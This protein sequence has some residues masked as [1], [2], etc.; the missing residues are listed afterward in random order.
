[1]PNHCV[2]TFAFRVVC[3][4]LLSTPCLPLSPQ[5]TASEPLA[6]KP[7]LSVQRLL[8]E[9]ARFADTDQFLDSLK[10][11]DQALDAAQK[12]S[13]LPGE[14]F[15]QQARGMAL[16]E[17]KRTDDAIV[18]W[19][20]AADVWVK[21]GDIPE[22]ITA[23]VHTGLLYSPDR[24]REPEHLFAQALALAKSQTRRPS[25]VAQILQDS[26][27]AFA[28][29]GQEQIAFNYLSAALMLWQKYMPESLQRLETLNA[30]AKLAG[31]CTILG[32]T[33]EDGPD[34]EKVKRSLSS[35][36]ET[37][38]QLPDSLEHVEM[39]TVLAN[40][41]LGRARTSDVHN[42]A[43][44][45]DYASRAVKL[46]TRLAPN[47]ALM[48]E[49]L[50][51]LAD[52]ENTSGVFTSTAE[53]AAKEHYLAALQIQQA[54]AQNG[55][56]RRGQLLASL[57]EAESKQT[58]DSARAKA[59]FE[60][61]IEVGERF[62]P[63]SLWLMAAHENLAVVEDDLGDLSDARSHLEQAFRI[64]QKLPGKFGPTLVNLGV[65]AVLEADFKSAR[66][67]F[68]RALAISADIKH[69][70]GLIRGNT[71]GARKLC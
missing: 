13:D 15:S 16:Q 34:L 4:V 14:A 71:V 2:R 59:H 26:G 56:S 48:V 37:E 70:T 24:K 57:A 19:Q 52:V 67:Y 69:P 5:V 61:A 11:A 41:S 42:F 39:L 31:D 25:A 36:Q 27:K 64:R 38:K 53:P 1:M 6:P 7:T 35:L 50:H 21:T 51:A 44:A 33:L 63:I 9:A 22:Q 20:S 58:A 30:L 49:A 68:E 43:T 8:D 47:S 29:E 40:R 28:D 46:A 17:L 54:L 10:T 3:L 18:A 55:S 32:V 12:A 60:E 65:H 66:D 23:L 45:K 62:A